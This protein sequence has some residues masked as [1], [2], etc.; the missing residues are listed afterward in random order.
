[1]VLGDNLFPSPSL[2]DTVS[3]DGKV[4]GNQIAIH[5]HSH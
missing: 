4:D 1:M 3:I 2:G 5:R